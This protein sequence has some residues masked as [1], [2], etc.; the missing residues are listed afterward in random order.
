MGQV[1]VAGMVEQH[2]AAVAAAVWEV[3]QRMSESSNTVIDHVAVVGC[4]ED[5]KDQ[6]GRLRT[7]TSALEFD[8]YLTLLEER[9]GSC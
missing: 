7:V 9:R 6:Q 5:W 2:F 3:G 4:L 8:R 1:G